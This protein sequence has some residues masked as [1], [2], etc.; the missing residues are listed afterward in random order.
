MFFYLFSGFSSS[1][2]F[3]QTTTDEIIQNYQYKMDM[4]A[5]IKDDRTIEPYNVRNYDEMNVELRK[6]N[7]ALQHLQNKTRWKRNLAR[8]IRYSGIFC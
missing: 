7:S 3:E 5:K 8:N 4:L 1:K 2:T 6:L